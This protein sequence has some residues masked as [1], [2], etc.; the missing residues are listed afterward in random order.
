MLRIPGETAAPLWP[1]ALAW[2]CTFTAA[3][4]SYV[5]IERPFL[6][7]KARL[8]RPSPLADPDTRLGAEL[9][10]AVPAEGRA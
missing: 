1:S 2:A 4:V 5:L 7:Y 3:L 9:S 6:A 8:V 10:P